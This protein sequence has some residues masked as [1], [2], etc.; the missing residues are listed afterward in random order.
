MQMRTV[1]GW[2]T[3]NLASNIALASVF[4]EWQGMK[5]WAPFY[6]FSFSTL[7]SCLPVFCFHG[8][9]TFL[10]LHSSNEFVAYQ[11]ELS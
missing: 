7:S 4:S 8:V 3:L 1:Y 6:S 10:Q 5:D 2:L 11:S 9:S